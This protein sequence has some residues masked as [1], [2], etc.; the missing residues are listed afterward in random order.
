MSV[1][2]LVTGG[3]GFIAHHFCEHL[4]K[5]TDWELVVLDRLSYAADG[6]NRLRDVQ[7]FDNRRVRIFTHDVSRPISVGLRREI[8]GL[9]YIVHM[10]AD[11]HVDNSI[12][13]P[14]CFVESNVMGTAQML[15]FA[16]TQ[17]NLKLFVQFSTDEVMGPA[18]EGETFD[19]WA[20]HNPT[21]PY[22]ATKAAADDLVLAWTNTYGLPAVITHCMNAFGERQHPEKYIPKIVRMLLADETLT[23]HADPSRSRAGSR[24]YIHG[25]NIAAAVLFLLGQPALPRREKFNIVGEREVDNLTLAQSIAGL[26]GRNL[27]Y[28]LVNFHETR[29]GHDLRYGL[30]G[31]RMKQMGWHIPVPFE[32]SLER[33]VHWMLRP[34]NMRWLSIT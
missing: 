7:A 13:E 32:E 18:A 9:D 17:E 12:A 10:A 25:R 16:R 28:T 21:N 23:I 31:E 4:L 20:R 3:C 29:P 15:E 33:T 2:M 6:F 8:G 26:M 24:F 19:E 27:K 34:E 1:R 30:S 14:L 22:A 11:T 5:N